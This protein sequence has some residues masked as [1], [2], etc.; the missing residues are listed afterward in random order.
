LSDVLTVDVVKGAYVADGRIKPKDRFLA[1]AAD[2]ND[3]RVEVTAPAPLF[4]GR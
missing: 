3:A 1:G 4:F 2:P